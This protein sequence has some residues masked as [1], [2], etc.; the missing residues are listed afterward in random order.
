MLWQED[1]VRAIGPAW[2][3]APHVI[4]PKA[5]REATCPTGTTDVIHE[6]AQ[7]DSILPGG[8]MRIKPLL[9]AEG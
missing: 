7:L 1:P 3:G 6:P 2:A 9:A 8:V 4:R 5:L